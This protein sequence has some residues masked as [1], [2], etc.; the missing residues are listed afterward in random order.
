MA[1]GIFIITHAAQSALRPIGRLQRTT[2][3]DPF[4]QPSE[5]HQ[6]RYPEK[7]SLLAQDELRIRGKKIRP[8]RGNRANGL[9]IDLKQKAPAIPVVPI[10]QPGELL[11][12]EGM[13]RMSHPH[14]PRGSDGRICI[15]D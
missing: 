2:S 15:R 1:S 9:V 11:S 13:E 8:L 12:A 14:K 5:L 10:A 4:Y 6:V 7:R 3:T